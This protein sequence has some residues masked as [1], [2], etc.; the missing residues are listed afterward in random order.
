[1]LNWRLTAVAIASFLVAG[2]GIG[3]LLK[4]IKSAARTAEEAAAKTSGLL[5]EILGNI[6]V[7]KAFVREAHELGRVEE[8]LA[9]LLRANLY[10]ERRA[11]LLLPL[12]N[13][14]GFAALVGV[15]LFSLGEMSA[16][17]STG[18]TLLAYLMYVG[19]MATALGQLANL[20]GRIAEGLGA[21]EGV[22]A[23]LHEEPEFVTQESVT[24]DRVTPRAG[25]GAIRLEEVTFSYPDASRPALA[26]VSLTLRPG[27]TVALVG[28]SGAGKSTLV[29]LLLGFFRPQSGTILLDGEP[30]SPLAVRDRVGIIF[31]EPYLFSRSVRDNIRYGRLDARDDE[32][33]EVAR[34]AQAWEF[35]AGMPQ[36]LDTLL[37][38]NGTGLSAG[39]KQRLA[40]ARALLKHGRL[41][42]LDEA[43]SAL[44]STNESLIQAALRHGAAERITLVVAHRL[45]TVQEADRIL[46]LDEGRIVE[47]G[48]HNSLVARGGLYA[49]LVQ[50]Q[51]LLVGG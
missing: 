43:T 31:Q 7:I 18:G 4:S 36:G 3:V 14:V 23:L 16:G 20:L 46:V 17:R 28:P 34:R 8:A 49:E 26:G 12:G 15:L 42:I 27:E 5:N 45:S 10:R 9:A 29:H 32:I 44:D 6:P 11:L 25:P 35:I 38:P 40:I 24:R 21:I 30:L 37:G 51:H 13:L 22:A 2:V 41:L 50:H 19:L 1:A 48:S 47:S 39:Q 33:E